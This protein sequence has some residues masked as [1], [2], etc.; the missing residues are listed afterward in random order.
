MIRLKFH[1]LSNTNREDML[2]TY[3]RHLHFIVV[4]NTLQ[5]TYRTHW[6]KRRNCNKT[7]L[8][9]K[10]RWRTNKCLFFCACFIQQA[11]SICNKFFSDLLLMAQI[12][13]RQGLA[14]QWEQ[15]ELTNASETTQHHFQATAKTNKMRTVCSLPDTGNAWKDYHQTKLCVCNHFFN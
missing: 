14:K 5:M 6:C 4:F 13:A 7:G 11:P 3:L 9:R 1:S 12:K 15:S 2:V 10:Q 8:W